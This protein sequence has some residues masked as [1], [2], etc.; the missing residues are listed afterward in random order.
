[1]LSSLWEG[2]GGIGCALLMVIAQREIIEDIVIY[3]DLECWSCTMVSFVRLWR[4]WVNFVRVTFMSANVQW[5]SK[6]GLLLSSDSNI[7]IRP[8]IIICVDSRG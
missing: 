2:W 5:S 8:N 4:K 6:C 3:W 7:T 1:L